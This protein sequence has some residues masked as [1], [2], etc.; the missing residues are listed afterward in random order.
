MLNTIQAE[1]RTL[2][3]HIHKESDETL[4]TIE[5]KTQIEF[6]GKLVDLNQGDFIIA[7]KGVRDRPACKDLVKALPIEKK[8]TLTKNNT[9]GTYET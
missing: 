2:N 9:V 3:F 1:N 6:S 4:Y 8:R 7:T 5:G